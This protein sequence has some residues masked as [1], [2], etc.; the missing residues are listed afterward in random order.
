MS[1]TKHADPKSTYAYKNMRASFASGKAKITAVILLISVILF[2]II[3]SNAYLLFNLGASETM[4]LSDENTVIS[5]SQNTLTFTNFDPEYRANSVAFDAR[6]SDP[7]N[8][9]EN[10]VVRFN[11]YVYTDQAITPEAALVIENEPFLIGRELDHRT[12]VFFGTVSERINKVVITYRDTQNGSFSQI[13]VSNIS[14]NESAS[15]SFNILRAVIFA[16]AALL[17]WAGVVF[18][19]SRSEFDSKKGTHRTAFLAVALILAVICIFFS[20]NM[21]GSDESVEYPLKSS[22]SSY[23]PYIQTFDAFMKGQLNIDMKPSDKLAS[24]ENPYDRDQRTEAGVEYEGWDRAYYDGNFYSYFG[25]APVIT[26]YAPYYLVSGSLPSDATVATFYILITVAFTLA[27]IWQWAKYH[28]KR[29]PVPLLCIGA[30]TAVISSFVFLIARG[31]N[32]F[33]YTA[34]LC[35]M[36]FTAMFAFFAITASNADRTKKVFRNVMWVLAGVSYALIML[37]R[38]NMALLVAFAVVPMLIFKILREDGHMRRFKDI[39]CELM[40]VGIPVIIVFVFT[41]WYNSARFGS[42]F[43]FGTTYQLTVSDIS[44]N[45]VSV[46]NILPTIFHYFFQ[47]FCM[48]AQFPYFWMMRITSS[49]YSD[50]S[51]GLFAIPLMIALP[52]GIVMLFNKRTSLYHKVLF[53]SSSV[54]LFVVALLNYSIGGV[55]F[56]YVCDLTLFAALMSLFVLFEFNGENM[57]RSKRASQIS[58]STRTRGKR[59]EVILQDTYRTSIVRTVYICTVLICIISLL[60]C[61]LVGLSMFL[62]QAQNQ[63]SNL[64]KYSQS[65]YM[66]FKSLFS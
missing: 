41:L 39:I 65:L 38:I 32:R 28:T 37:A 62:H 14:L 23:N 36:A 21:S 13:N 10:F 19:W 47:P 18:G 8:A 33:Y 54:G 58:S 64:V 2:E 5:G 44:K 34:V 42:M 48:G 27:A 6:Y 31:N 26:L 16:V 55:I 30:L 1:R 57:I 7:E 29:L 51:F 59:E 45:K 12:V 35:G 20:A 63:T 49:V 50:A 66:A 15:F 17:V 11:L 9:N 43:E 4:S 22:V 25:I 61:T 56:R 60:V 46:E 24:L 52:A 3:L 53:A 40:C